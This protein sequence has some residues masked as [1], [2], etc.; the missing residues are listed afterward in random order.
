MSHSC[1]WRST[2]CHCHICDINATTRGSKFWSSKV[3]EGGESRE[4]YACQL[5][6]DPPEFLFEIKD[7]VTQVV[8]KP[9]FDP[10]S[11]SL[12]LDQK[13]NL[14]RNH[15]LWIFD[16]L[17]LTWNLLFFSCRRKNFNRFCHYFMLLI[18]KQVWLINISLENMTHTRILTH[19]SLDKKSS[20]KKDKA[21]KRLIFLKIECK[22]DPRTR[23]NTFQKWNLGYSLVWKLE[24]P[25]H[26]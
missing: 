25:W 7:H 17:I 21:D 19:T 16:L 6:F 2:A 14:T 26:Q 24:V 20:D 3:C 4:A 13:W 23:R 8:R 10:L 9:N 15:R 18:Y 5:N 11:N 22:R 1:Q 12:K